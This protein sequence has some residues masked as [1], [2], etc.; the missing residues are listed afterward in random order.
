MLPCQEKD[1]GLTVFLSLFFLSRMHCLLN[2]LTFRLADNEIGDL[3]IAQSVCN[4]PLFPL[5]SIFLAKRLH[6]S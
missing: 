5:N 1:D 3:V 4:S 2:R 6:L